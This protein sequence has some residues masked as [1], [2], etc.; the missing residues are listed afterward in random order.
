MHSIL[1]KLQF[2]FTKI[3]ILNI[4]HISMEILRDADAKN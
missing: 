1:V 3:L 2:Q 4:I